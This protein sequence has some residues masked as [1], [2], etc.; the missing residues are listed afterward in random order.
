MRLKQMSWTFATLTLAT[1]ALELGLVFLV[2]VAAGGQ[3]LT[4]LFTQAMGM[5][6]SAFLITGAVLIGLIAT[7]LLSAIDQYQHR[8]LTRRLT[9][10]VAGQTDAPVLARQSQAKAALGEDV[11]GEL[12]ALR[13]KMIRLQQEIERYSNAPVVLDGQTKEQILTEERHRLA[14]EL[15]DSV[16]QQLFAA[17][18]MLS[19]LRSVVDRDNPDAPEA[20]QIETI[21][22]VINEAQSEMR[23]LLLHLR[24]TNLAGKSLKEGI[25]SLLQELQTKIKIAISWD[26]QDIHLS[27]G[28]EDNL[29]RIVQELLSNTLR[30]AKAKHLEVYLK[31]VEATVVLRVV[32]DGVGFDP[33]TENTTGS[34]GLSNISERA[35]AIGG[36]AKVISVPKQGTS[37]EIRVPLTKE[38]AHD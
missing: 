32:D 27:R 20:K 12:E 14:R 22:G 9:Q 31:Q 37:V 5:P 36:T 7:T 23:A 8:Q 4:L 13:Q 18:M 10:L 11:A 25:I 33:K 17:M 35:A 19:A 26:L 16:S 30:H 2:S 3:F 15:H 38:E 34:Y 29:F 28:S 24:P 6:L 21:E 1:G